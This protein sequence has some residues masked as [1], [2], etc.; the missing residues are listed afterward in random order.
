MDNIFRE[1][2][3]NPHELFAVAW[4][5]M[6]QLK[7]VVPRV[8]AIAN[9]SFHKSGP[10]ITVSLIG[11]HC[12][13][14]SSKPHIYTIFEDYQH[15]SNMV[16]SLLI[17][18][19]LEFTA[20]FG[21]VPRRFFIGADNTP[22]E[23]KN[24][25][26]LFC[27]VWLLS[28]LYMTELVVIE[29]G[30]LLVGHT[31]NIV[32]AIFAWLNKALHG[33]D[34]LSLVDMQNRAEAKM[35]NPPV[36][37]HLRDVYDFHGLQPVEFG[38]RSLKGVTEPH[39]YRVVRAHDDSICV[40]SKRF[41]TSP[42]WSVPQVVATREQC[43]ELR[44]MWPREVMPEWGPG[45]ENSTLSFLT[46]LKASLSVARPEASLAGIEHCEQLMK[47]ELPE[48]LPTHV[49]LREKL[50][51]VRRCSMEAQV[52]DQARSSTSTSTIVAVT[53]AVEGV[54]RTVF[55]KREH[56]TEVIDGLIRVVHGDGRG[57]HGYN[58]TPLEGGATIIYRNRGDHRDA[59]PIRLGKVLRFVDEDPDDVYV[60]VES[61]W[62]IPKIGK[63]ETNRPNMFGTWVPS[64][65][66]LEN[67][68]DKPARKR[69]RAPDE[70]L[71]HSLVRRGDVLVWPISEVAGSVANGSR[72][73]FTAFH[74]L[75]THCQIDLSP[76]CFSFSE[77]GHE[78]YN[79]VVREVGST[80][81]DSQ[82][83][84]DA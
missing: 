71:N 63:Y 69:P 34:V 84:R 46:R 24:T 56:D 8:L 58:A 11:A 67:Y 1:S 37:D 76:K 62:P 54:L 45:V 73:P 13:G 52:R 74:Y 40:Q 5:K 50:G 30:F 81:R 51:R 82:P 31:H 49:P 80:I 41:L 26:V 9:T 65:V 39:H 55:N 25:I 14:L 21:T 33:V 23:T 42:T 6:D 53:S 59:V 4:D 78:F 32:D 19:L 70:H 10:R 64:D 29:F 22:K 75:R 57:Q 12:P 48:F 72:I 68:A 60:I 61:W 15:G 43:D 7:T 17:T 79:E 66:A 83:I 3:R 38:S 2:E 16:C 20:K 44:K 35:E 47:H 77:R 36:W 27:A 18:M 28:H